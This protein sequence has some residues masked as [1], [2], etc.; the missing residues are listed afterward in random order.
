MFIKSANHFVGNYLVF[1]FSTFNYYAESDLG[2][3][4]AGENGIS[5]G[6]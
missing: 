2:K 3:Y 5:V 1:Q 6:T 4:P